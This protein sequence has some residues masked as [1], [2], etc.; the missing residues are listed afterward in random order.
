[1]LGV[2]PQVRGGLVAVRIPALVAGERQARQ[3]AV[4][5]RGEQREGVVEVRPRAAGLLPRLEDGEV[6]GGG[7]QRVRGGESGWPAPMTMTS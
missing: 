3:R 5:R 2:L 6:K 4:L 1:V 7:T